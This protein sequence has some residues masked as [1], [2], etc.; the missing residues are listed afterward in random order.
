M[1]AEVGRSLCWGAEKSFA[2]RTGAPG[3]LPMG[4]HARGR[5]FTIQVAHFGKKR[6][7]VSDICQAGCRKTSQF[8]SQVQS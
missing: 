6:L 2:L 5:L 3:N 7:L 4:W 1:A 8:L